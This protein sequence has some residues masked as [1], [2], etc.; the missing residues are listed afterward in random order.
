MVVHSG[1]DQ[2]RQPISY[3]Y[4]I[5]SD[6]ATLALSANLTSTRGQEGGGMHTQ[7]DLG[8]YARR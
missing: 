7:I 3:S 1:G 4:Q 6:G 5:E 2:G 8:G